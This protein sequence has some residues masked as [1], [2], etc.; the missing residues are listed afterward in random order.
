MDRRTALKLVAAA[1]FA[2]AFTWTGTDAAQ[3]GLQAKA[4]LKEAARTG[5]S[6]VPEFFTEREWSVV[7]LLV[8]LI[9]PADDRSV[10]ASDAG[11]PEFMDF[12]MTDVPNRQTAMRGGLAWLER[13]A[14]ERFGDGFL[15]I[16]DTQR[17]A[18]LDDIA[19]P[20]RGRP[21]HSQGTAFF[22][23]FRDLTANGFWS[24]RIGID[25]LQYMGNT[26]V[27]EWTGCPPEA[28]AKLGVR[29][30]D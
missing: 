24:S 30:E 10:G 17:T 7:R 1:P 27:P 22:T 9:I 8:D 6:Y 21:E 28:L 11:V 25:D 23:S 26:V 29:Y 2:G 19:W 18:I 14:R 15:E 20:A 3:A 13:E 4:V 16:D 5:T 12:M